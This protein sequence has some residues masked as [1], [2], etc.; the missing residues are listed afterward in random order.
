MKAILFFTLFSVISLSAFAQISYSVPVPQELAPYAIFPNMESE[1]IHNGNRLTI[2]YPLPVELVGAERHVISISGRREN[3]RH[4]RLRGD[5]ADA[6]CNDIGGKLSCT[7]EYKDLV[8]NED[9]VRDAIMQK[10]PDPF[11]QDMRLQVAQIFS[12]EPIGIITMTLY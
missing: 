3:P 10:F 8:I 9:A 4:F 12:G 7:V 6:H 5:K 1:Y 11:E 2:R